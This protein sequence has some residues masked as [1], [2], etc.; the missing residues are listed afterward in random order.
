[1]AAQYRSVLVDGVSVPTTDQGACAIEKLQEQNR[2]LRAELEGQRGVADAL[3]SVL[4]E[5]QKNAPPDARQA[6][7]DAR[8]GM[9]SRIGNAYKS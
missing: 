6:A 3:G 9:I 1:M 5:R 2:A 4:A 7:N 8:R